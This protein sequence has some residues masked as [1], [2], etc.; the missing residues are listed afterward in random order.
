MYPEEQ[1]A[2]RVIKAGASGYL[3]K[4]AATQ[5]LINAVQRFLTGRKYIRSLQF[6]SMILWVKGNTGCF[7]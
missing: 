6:K 4:Q 1:Y 3:K 7:F 2:F 5:E